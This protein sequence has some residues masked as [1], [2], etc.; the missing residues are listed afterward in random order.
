M[1]QRGWKPGT[2][3]ALDDIRDSVTELR[4]YRS[5]VFA[6]PATVSE[7]LAAGGAPDPAS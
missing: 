2:H 4:Y 7:R 5:A 6:S 1:A 3:R